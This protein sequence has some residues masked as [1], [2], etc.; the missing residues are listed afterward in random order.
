MF[1]SGGEAKSS[2]KGHMPLYDLRIL[3]VLRAVK[4][5][6]VN[7]QVKYFQHE[8]LSSFWLK[9]K[10]LWSEQHFVISDPMWIHFLNLA[11]FF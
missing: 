4:K 10:L 8:K 6:T 7:S 2:V 3:L 11:F 5:P 1:Q 9:A